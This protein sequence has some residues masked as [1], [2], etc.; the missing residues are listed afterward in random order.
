MTRLAIFDLDGTLTDTNAVDGECY[1]EAGSAELGLTLNPDWSSYPHCTD[2]GIAREAL[3]AFFGRPG[4]SEEIDRWRGRFVA[5]LR[6]RLAQDPARFSEIPGAAALLSRLPEEGWYLCIATGGWSKSA[7]LK[8]Q[9]AGLPQEVPIFSSDLHHTREGILEIAIRRMQ[10]LNGVPSYDRI[11]SLGDG[12]WDVSAAAALRLPFVGVGRG[13]RA[14]RLRAAGALAVLGDFADLA[15]TLE[16]IASAE[17]P[18][19]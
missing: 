2:A 7:E 5:L 19:P 15:A 10:E 18:S 6:D 1:L 12:V 13:A 14:D 9:A 16:T 17:P 11:V 3:A 8:R 4:S